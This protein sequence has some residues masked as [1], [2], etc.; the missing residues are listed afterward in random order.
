MSVNRN[1]EQF[2]TTGNKK[3]LLTVNRR[4]L[5]STKTHLTLP[6]KQPLQNTT[7]QRKRT[8]LKYSRNIFSISAYDVT[9]RYRPHVE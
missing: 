2:E 5:H 6:K 3:K 8:N 1:W 4:Y 7:V 9:L